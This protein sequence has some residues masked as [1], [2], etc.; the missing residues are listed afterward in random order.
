[1]LIAS[2]SVHFVSTL[3]RENV[4]IFP[5]NIQVC[6]KVRARESFQII[7]WVILEI[8]PMLCISRF[9]SCLVIDPSYVCSNT[10][11]RID[12]LGKVRSGTH[13]HLH[14]TS[15]CTNIRN[16]RHVFLLIKLR[17]I[18]FWKIYRHCQRCSYDTSTFYPK[19]SQHILNILPMTQKEISLCAI[20]PDLHSKNFRICAHILYL[21]FTTL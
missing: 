15:H 3:K 13:H 10:C 18:E 7:L 4:L 1:M 14:Q 5:Y 6:S 12:C 20:P 16:T 2:V 11:T 19:M 9:G 8:I 21:K 17:N